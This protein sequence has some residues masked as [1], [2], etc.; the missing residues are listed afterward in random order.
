MSDNSNTVQADLE[1]ILSGCNKRKLSTEEVDALQR[2]I[3]TYQQSEARLR[4]KSASLASMI[5]DLQERTQ[6]QNGVM[7]RAITYYE[8]R[9]TEIQ[10]NNIRS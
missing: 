9:H 1:V 3:S 2:A 5:A 7:N 6:S 10:R 8:S 4:H